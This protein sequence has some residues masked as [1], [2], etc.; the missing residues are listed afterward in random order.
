M[1]SFLVCISGT[2][3]R[4]GS[5]L[6]VN[7][8]RVVWGVRGG[9]I[10]GGLP[11]EHPSFHPTYRHAPCRRCSHF[12]SYQ[13]RIWVLPVLSSASR[14]NNMEVPRIRQL[15]SRPGP[16]EAGA[17]RLDMAGSQQRAYKG[18]FL[19]EASS[20]RAG[21]PFPPFL[22]SF[23]AFNPGTSGGSLCVCFSLFALFTRFPPSKR[24]AAMHL[25]TSP[26]WIRDSSSFVWIHL[27]PVLIL[28]FVL[29][30]RIRFFCLS[31]FIE[32]WV[33]GLGILRHKE[34]F[35]EH[36]TP[37]LHNSVL[38][39]AGWLQRPPGWTTSRF[40]YDFPWVPG[41]GVLS[42]RWTITTNVYSPNRDLPRHIRTIE[43]SRRPTRGHPWPVQHNG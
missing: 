36:D 8:R 21:H 17:D 6:L 29:G 1:F 34:V 31:W 35:L 18:C 12:P 15:V 24:I 14:R 3:A 2:E 27:S 5:F 13:A 40:S 25:P 39:Q 32:L 9:G 30:Y 16:A 28:P 20:S 23:T 19:A 41:I 26:A 7:P 43:E 10:P 22:F 4:K 38:G 11:L 37:L 42:T 33:H